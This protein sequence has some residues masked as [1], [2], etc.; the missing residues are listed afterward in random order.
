MSK[1]MSYVAKCKCGGI[2]MATMDIPNHAE[3]VAK[4]VASCLKAGFRI[5]RMSCERVR[6]AAWCENQGKC[7]ARKRKRA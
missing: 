1:T 4:E 6:K 5:T 3:D 7:K 2:V